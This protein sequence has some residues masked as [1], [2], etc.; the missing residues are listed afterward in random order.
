MAITTPAL[1][2]T[3]LPQVYYRDSYLEFPG[4]RGA[5]VEMASGALSTDLVSTSI[6]RRFELAWVAMTEAQVATIL[7][8][9]A[10]VRDGSASFTSP[11]GGSYT[12]TRDVAAM[13]VDLSWYRLGGVARADVRMRLREV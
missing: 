1:G 2:G 7:T 5:D 10:T 8:A 12:V 13:E 6:K 11:L 4:Y 3:T 9:F